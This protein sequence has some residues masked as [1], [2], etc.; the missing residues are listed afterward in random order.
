VF[1]LPSFFPFLHSTATP[2][3]SAKNVHEETCGGELQGMFVARQHQT[4]FR[5]V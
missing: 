3:A 1:K 5:R 4:G 2:G